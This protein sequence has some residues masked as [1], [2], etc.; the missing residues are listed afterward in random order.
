MDVAER[1]EIKAQ[2]QGWIRTIRRWQ[3][4][5]PPSLV[6]VVEAAAAVEAMQGPVIPLLP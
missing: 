1:G 2:R 3:I 5:L 6:A 4:S